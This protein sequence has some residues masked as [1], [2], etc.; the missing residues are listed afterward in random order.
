[1]V[2]YGFFMVFYGYF[3]LPRAYP[4]TKC[5]S[6]LTL[7]LRK[8]VCWKINLRESSCW[9]IRTHRSSGL[10]TVRLLCEFRDFLNASTCCARSSFALILNVS[11]KSYINNFTS[12]SR[13]LKTTSNVL[14]V[15]CETWSSEKH[16]KRFQWE[17]V[18]RLELSSQTT[19]IE[20]DGIVWF[21]WSS[22]RFLQCASVQV[23][24]SPGLQEDP[25]NSHGPPW[26][27]GGS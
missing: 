24:R 4:R 19:F 18:K 13:E 20:Q 16:T 15:N 3:Y 25:E 27:I 17:L 8:Y 23:L 26:S 22:E 14:R 10:S 9:K 11:W 2:C 6:W 12:H 7:N 1:M 21:V 5:F